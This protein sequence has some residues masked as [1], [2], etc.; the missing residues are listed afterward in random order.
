MPFYS[1][2]DRRIIKI[3]TLNFLEIPDV[4]AVNYEQDTGAIQQ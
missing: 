3:M 2:L 1:V 4:L